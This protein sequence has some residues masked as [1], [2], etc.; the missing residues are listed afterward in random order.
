MGG[1]CVNPTQFR[2]LKIGSLNPPC[3]T[4]GKKNPWLSQCPNSGCSLF[5]YLPFSVELHCFS[6]GFFIIFH[7]F[8][9]LHSLKL[10]KKCQNSIPHFTNSITQTATLKKITFFSPQN[11]NFSCKTLCKSFFNDLVFTDPE[12]YFKKNH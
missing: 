7:Q 9:T 8:L 5:G 4:A 6:Y 11:P 3:S 10:L 1:A 2:I 12:I